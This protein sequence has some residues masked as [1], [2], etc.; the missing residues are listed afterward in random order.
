MAEVLD[1]LKPGEITEPI[2]VQKGY[3]LFKLEARSESVPEPFS[4][5]RDQITA[6]IYESRLDGETKKF[7]EKLRT[8]AL[9][10]WKD[11][12]Y[13]QMYEK[14]RSDGQDRGSKAEAK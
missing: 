10:E 14:V 8:Q 4:K 11:D 1:K 12:G 2:R 5:V 3:T 6:K 13:R 7:L 9:I